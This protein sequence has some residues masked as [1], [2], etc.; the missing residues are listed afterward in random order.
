MA[1]NITVDPAVL[2]AAAAQMDS[3]AGDYKTTYTK[4]FSEVDGMA[5]NWG[6]KDNIAYT[7]QIKG[8]T[9]DFQKMEKLMRDYSDFLKK[10]AAAYRKT[11]QEIESQAKTLKN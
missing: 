5:A 4:L 11:Q 3:Y 7:T 8:F 2:D 9:D 10:T 1:K 6:G